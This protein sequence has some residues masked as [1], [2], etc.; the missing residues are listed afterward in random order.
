MFTHWSPIRSTQRMMCSSAASSR[1][2]SAD[3]RLAPEQRE[4]ALVDLQVATVDPVVVGHDHAG[5]L[6]VLVVD[7]LERAVELGDDQ[8]KPAHRL[9]LKPD[10]IV[11]EAVARCA[12][13]AR[14][15]SVASLMASTS[16]WSIELTIMPRR[17][18]LRREPVAEAEVRVDE[19]PVRQRGVELHPQLADVHVDRAVAGAHLAPPDQPEQL[20]TGDDPVGPAR[21]LGQQPQL[22]EGQ[23]QRVT[24]G[25][26][27]MLIG[28]DLKRP[29]VRGARRETRS[30]A[31]ADMLTML[32]HA[33]RTAA[34]LRREPAVN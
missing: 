13:A 9:H 30:D 14:V 12:R 32:V 1:R 28:H 6:D 22:P 34:L 18:A 21:Q 33:T 20:L 5:Q 11:T 3:R 25:T 19:A 17:P 29:D 16:L 10:Q 8:V 26:R 31:V 2:S 27:Q 24:V 23:R 7:R 4:H 15:F